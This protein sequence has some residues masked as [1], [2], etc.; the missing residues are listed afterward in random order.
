[1]Q[2]ALCKI[3]AREQNDFVEQITTSYWLFYALLNNQQFMKT[4]FHKY[5][6]RFLVEVSFSCRKDSLSLQ[7]W[8]PPILHSQLNLKALPRAS[9]TDPSL[10]TCI[11]VRQ[12]HL[13]VVAQEHG[14]MVPSSQ[15]EA[16]HLQQQSVC[17][18]SPNQEFCQML[19]KLDILF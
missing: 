2:Q 8:M 11:C 1:M 4:K 13:S 6:S 3:G 16:H 5:H 15:T 12:H 19:A 9:N 10:Q 14:H 18:C 7:G 17:L